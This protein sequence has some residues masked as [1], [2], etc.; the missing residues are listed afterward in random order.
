MWGPAPAARTQQ[1]LPEIAERRHQTFWHQQHKG[2][3]DDAED[4]RRVGQYFGPPVRPG[5]LG[6]P[7]RG[8]EPL[9]ADAADDR[10]DQRAA[11]TDDDPD[12]DLRRLTEAQDG[13]AE[14]LARIAKRTS[15]K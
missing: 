14:Q 12:D 3:Q 10:A 11:A 5:G 13:R 4:Q 9:D 1:P 7:K 8:G 15:G 6:R 2:D